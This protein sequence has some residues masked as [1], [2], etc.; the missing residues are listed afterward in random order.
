MELNGLKEKLVPI[1]RSIR[2]ILGQFDGY[3][4]YEYS[5]MVEYNHA[6]PEQCQMA[7]VLYTVLRHLEDAHLQME[8]MRLPVTH[9]G[10]LHQNANGRYECDGVELTCGS[11]VEVLVSDSFLGER[12]WYASH[13]EA[14]NGYYL[15][16]KKNLDLEGMEARIRGR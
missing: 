1:D 2:E 5:G 15:V 11:P 16:G 8:Y 12:E 9:R 7:S 4:E 14:D 6:D 13:I 10:R 3:L